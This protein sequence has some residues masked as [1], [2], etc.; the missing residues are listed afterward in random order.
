MWILSPGLPTHAVIG[1]GCSL[2]HLFAYGFSHQVLLW[3][4]FLVV[5]L[6]SSIFFACGFFHPV[7]LCIQ[8]LVVDLLSSIFLHVDSLTRFCCL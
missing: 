7:L 8:L 2:K 1:S 5:D 6:L 3:I 4:W